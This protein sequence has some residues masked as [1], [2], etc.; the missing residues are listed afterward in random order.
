MKK[1]RD[2]DE[3]GPG[4]QEVMLKL[5]P[6]LTREGIRALSDELGIKEGDLIYVPRI[7]SW[8]KNAA[9]ELAGSGIGGLLARLPRSS[10]FDPQLEAIFRDVSIPLLSAEMTGVQV[11]GG[12]ITVPRDRLDAAIRAWDDQQRAYER[13]KKKTLLEDIYREYRTER[14]KEM[15]KVG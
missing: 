10:R 9:R 13:E 12:I 15:K 14:G 6:S 11:K 2:H 8:G 1:I 5:L 3:A 4:E 7:D